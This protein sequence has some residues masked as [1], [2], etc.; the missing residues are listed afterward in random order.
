MRK[1]NANGV[2]LRRNSGMSGSP[3]VLI[4]WQTPF[5]PVLRDVLL[6]VTDGNPGNAIVVFP[7]DRPKRYL[8]DL[9]R[10]ANLPHAPG[11]A[12][13]LPRMFTIREFFATL[14]AC[15]PGPVPREAS[16]LD[17]VAL[18]W[19]AVKHVS[20]EDSELSA[21]LSTMDQ[22]TF[23]PW[24]LQLATVLE[25]CL[26][27]GLTPSDLHHAEGEVAPFAAALLGILG[28]IFT[29]YRKSLVENQLSTPGLDA[30]TVSSSLDNATLLPDR[31]RNRPLLLVGFSA[32]NG[33][34]DRLFHHLWGHG[35][36]VCIQG[37]PILAQGLPASCHHG[38]DMLA[39]WIAR[40]K[41]SCY[42]AGTAENAA[43]VYH[44][45]SGHDLHSQLEAMQ[46]DLR[47]TTRDR[48]ASGLAI[49]LT[50]ANALLPAL[51]HLPATDCN[52]SLGYPLEKT[53][54][55]RL[56]DTILQL[57]STSTPTGA[58]HWKRLAELVRHP[59][60]RM[61]SAD[62][63]PLR[64]ALQCME[65]QLRAG[66]RIVD[67]FAVA[68]QGL[69]KSESSPA[70]K[71]LLERVLN[72]TIRNWQQ[73]QTTADLAECLWALCQLLTKDGSDIWS[74]FPLEAEGLFRLAQKVI[75]AL[76]TTL[77]ANVALPWPLATSILKELIATERIP[78]EADPLTGIQVLGMLE[79][80][81]LHFQQVFI[82]DVTEDRLPGS[83]TISPLLPDSLR[84]ALGL[85]DTENRDKLAAY[86]FFR[87]LA[88]AQQ[89]YLYWQEGVE[90][91]SFSGGRKQRSRFVEELVWQEEKKLGRLLLPGEGIIRTPALQLRPIEQERAAI[92][93]TDRIQ[94]TVSRFLQKPISPSALNDYLTCPVKFWY[95]YL[96]GLAPLQSV[97]ET[98]DP[99]SVGTLLHNT[100]QTY[101]TPF[102]G[103]EIDHRALSADQ[104]V[105]IFFQRLEASALLENLPPESLAMLR[106][107]GPKRLRLFLEHQ[108]SR[109]RVLALEH[110]LETTLL[111]TPS[112][113]LK[114]KGRLDRVDERYEDDAPYLCVLDYK[115]GSVR[116]PSQ[117]A[118]DNDLFDELAFLLEASPETFSKRLDHTEEDLLPQIGKL[119]P[120]L[121]LPAYLFLLREQWN[122][123]DN[124]AFVELKTTGA[125]SALFAKQCDESWRTEIIETK[126]PLLLRFVARHMA[127]CPSFRPQEGDHCAWCA[128]APYCLKAV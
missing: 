86:T 23:F 45:F 39:R 71:A 6:E 120:S 10:P 96:C 110:T 81:L 59:C 58:V 128:A 74:R 34:E 68:R 3:F 116:V 122:R 84:G 121:Q 26:N 67:P 98:D 90:S 48:T 127:L 49:V 70:I 1:N 94:Q 72:A 93:R 95:G 99:V 76:R 16:S 79:T 66:S 11:K 24:G 18:L 73:A 114:L 53:L 109:V 126:I 46:R 101:Y 8:T 118:W 78:F 97:L 47:A 112:M 100:L 115:T 43:P 51:H 13:I 5:L 125:E 62:G 77:M 14:R 42:L 107:A 4:P 52:I 33:S 105:H 60:L 75:P 32:L 55:S 31:L 17:Q 21:V 104:L 119:F 113:H 82:V 38:C 41:A 7:H 25:E 89:A 124:A 40:W 106:T 64:N 2:P 69:A 102:I 30:F 65:R 50:H 85:P 35:A 83:A 57:R 61:L 15:Q 54:L 20:A 123:G 12:V 44:F 22:S 63:V 80:R 91:G 19:Q 117:R 29:L 37:D 56:V 92:F 111:K 9:F 103:Q 88:G 27:N 87:L 108:P 28:Q 36:T